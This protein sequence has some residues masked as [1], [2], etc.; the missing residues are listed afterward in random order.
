[1]FMTTPAGIRVDQTIFNDA[2][3]TG[4]DLPINESWNSFW[5]V[6]TTID[7]QGWYAEMRIP[8][9]SLRFQDDEG[10]VVMGLITWRWIARKS[11]GH[12][13]PE[14][15]PDWYLAHIKP[16]IARDVEFTDVYS[17]RPFFVAPYAL[18]GYSKQADLN[19]PETAYVIDEEPTSDIGLDVKVGLTSNLTLDLTLNTDFA[20]VESDDA[21]VNLT[22]FSL[23]FPEKRLFFQERSS[24]FDFRT[25]GPTRLFYSRTIGL[26]DDG[27]VR[28]Y[29]GAR[30]IGRLGG[31]DIGAMD[32]QTAAEHDLPSENFGV[33]RLRRR[34]LN[35]NSYVG[36]MTTSRIGDDGT[37][38]VAYGFDGLLRLFGDDYLSY[39]LAHSVEDS[40]ID[41]RSAAPAN[42]GLAR[43]VWERRKNLGVGYSLDVKWVGDAYNP[44]L[45]FAPRTDFTRIGASVL[46]GVLAR[47]R[48]PV[49]THTVFVESET[50]VRNS[51][52]VVESATMGP[53]YFLNLRT[54]AFLFFAPRLLIEDIDEE[55][56]LSDEVVV[57]AGRYTFYGLTVF[58][59][60][61]P[62]LISGEGRMT[63]GTFY[64]GW[65]VSI[66]LGPTWTLS[67][68]IE[69]GADFQLNRV[70]FPDRDQTFSGDILRVRGRMALNTKLSS[71]VLAQYDTAD[72]RFDLNF[73]LRYN[74]SEGHD[75]WFVYN[76]GVNTDR[77]G[78]EPYPPRTDNRTILAKYTYTFV[79]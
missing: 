6:A 57:P 16:S 63:V 43:L 55:F 45:G 58:S 76:E 2:D 21:Q 37:Y 30:L 50:Y 70:G 3:F 77:L 19:D 38:N 75:L 61:A 22:R 27:P 7:G 69:L 66:G 73:R 47:E 67:R 64:D 15:P 28:I 9:S 78:Q 59:Q 10:K 42:S 65:R 4:E 20:Q 25:G 8:F 18:G 26:S 24:V 39:N 23:F 74:F 53:S 40:L 49:Y 33:M 13:F 11:E 29:G 79:L 31:W 72:D 48:S 36:A 34:V 44:G 71:T 60:T 17:R 62:R 1:M 68:H 14:L 46:Y 12:T 5:D 52:G 51:D 54:G 35:Q 32:L 41:I 56:E